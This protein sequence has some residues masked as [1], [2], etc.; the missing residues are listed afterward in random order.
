MSAAEGGAILWYYTSNTNTCSQ[1]ESATALPSEWI[2]YRDI[3]IDMIEEAYQKGMPHLLLDRYRIDLAT[4]THVVLDT[5]DEHR[6]TKREVVANRITGLRSNR[7]GSL[8][9][10]T[11]T[12]IP[13]PT[14]GAYSTW[15]PFLTAWLNTSAGKRILFQFSS[16]IEICAEGIIEEAKTHSNKVTIEAAYMAKKIQECL[17]KPRVEVS[18]TAI[19]L[20]TKDSFLYFALNKAV[21]EYDLSKLFTLGPL[22]FLIN[23]YASVAEEFVGIVYRGVQLTNADIQEYRQAIG[24]WKTWPAYTSTSKNRT[25][26][27]AYGN[28]LFVIEI[29]HCPL[30]APRNF[31]IAEFSSFPEEEEVLLLAGCSFQVVHVH[32]DLRQKL[33]IDARI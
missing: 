29:I 28:T 3:E 7:F 21:R 22:C 12:S 23:D 31:D 13:T 26:A 11:S 10:I 9:G 15:C 24:T 6:V 20:Y 5:S 14:Y 19:G 27:E 33:I 16:C 17:N 32:Y 4:Y 2:L 18:K 30:S 25:L 1:S 8:P